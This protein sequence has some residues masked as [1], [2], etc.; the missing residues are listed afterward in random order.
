MEEIYTLWEVVE[1]PPEK[2]IYIILFQFVHLQQTH[3]I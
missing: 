3:F 1:A 2:I